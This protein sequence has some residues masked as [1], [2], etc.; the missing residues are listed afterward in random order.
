MTI[1]H[2]ESIVILPRAELEA[3]LVEAANK[4]ARLALAEAKAPGEKVVELWDAKQVGE[5]LGLSA[6]TIANGTSRERGFPA[7]VILG[8]GPK[9]RRRWRPADVVAWA[10]RKSRAA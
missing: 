7:P 6:Y 9:A 1:T 2:T 4:G 8:A 3:M 5:Y 10:G